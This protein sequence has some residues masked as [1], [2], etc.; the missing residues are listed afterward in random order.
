MPPWQQ[1]K[2]REAYLFGEERHGDQQREN[3]EPFINHPLE[4][5]RVLGDMHMDCPTIVA[6]ILHD[7]IEDTSTDK[8]E[9]RRRFGREVAEL[10]DGVT[11]LSRIRSD[12][13]RQTQAGNLHKM[14]LA[15]SRDI[16][17]ILIKLADRLHNMR[18]LGALPRAKRQRIARETLDIYAPI[19]NRLGMNAIRI[20]LENLSLQGLYPRRYAV[21][22]KCLRRRNDRRALV[23]GKVNRSLEQRFRQEGMNVRVSG[24]EKHLYGIYQ[25]M[26]ERRMRFNE[27]DDVHALR[28]ITAS[29]RDCYVALGIIHSLH[30]PVVGKFKDYIS[31]PKTNGYQSLHTVLFGHG[32]QLIEVQI[33]SEEMNLIAEAGIASHWLYKTDEGKDQHGANRKVRDWLQGVLELQRSAGDSEEFLEH[34]RIDLFPDEVYV[35]TPGGDILKLPKSSTGLDMAY[36]IHSDIG[37]RCHEVRIDGQPAPL[38]THLESGQTVEVVTSPLARPQ[39]EWLGFAV[40][41]KARLNIR[42]SLVHVRFSEARQLGLKILRVE[43]QA[44]HGDYDRLP[45]ERMQRVLQRHC[46]DSTELLLEQIGMGSIPAPLVAREMVIEDDGTTATRALDKALVITGEEQ[47]VLNY[48]KCCHPLPDDHIIGHLSSGRGI[49]IHRDTCLNVPA[50]GRHADQ[51]FRAAWD[52]HIQEEFNAGLCLNV[53]NRQGVLAIVAAAISECN[54]NITDVVVNDGWD[55]HSELRFEV[56]VRNRLHLAQIIRGLRGIP[57][58][59][60]IRRA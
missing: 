50:A 56:E 23:V 27:I 58:V 3:G 48:G 28:V 8:R 18:T 57:E 42:Q 33:R 17:V 36:A 16:R 14:F 13:L 35:F 20:E 53:L 9:I 34:M 52:P 11:K 55:R 29:A 1:D 24:R 15:M 26:R 45:P 60:T 19:A 6:A 44:L 25:K 22:D 47:W 38:S 2:I 41:A 59:T 10:V 32:G 12:T 30:K 39:P 49:V 40:T 43:L 7:V 5:G 21:L 51:W 37:D 54:S 4:V 46:L 31:I